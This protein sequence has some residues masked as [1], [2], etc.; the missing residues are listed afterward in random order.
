MCAGKLRLFDNNN[1]VGEREEIVGQIE[2]KRLGGLEIDHQL[3]L[4]RRLRR[5]AGWL[6][7]PAETIHR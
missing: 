2:A 6:P 4:G 1:L 5:Q 7:A 3:E